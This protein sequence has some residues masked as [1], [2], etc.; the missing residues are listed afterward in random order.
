M[1]Q[2]KK[3]KARHILVEELED[4]QYILEKLLE[5]EDFEQLALEF[6][7]CD[8]SKRGGNLGT[9]YSGQ[10]TGPFE[11]ALHFLK[12]MEISAPI[13]SEFGHQIIQRLPI[14]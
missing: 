2:R 1:H 8:S 5:G 13:K 11:K 10:M 6:S 14:D 4:A 7:E 9:F 12:D 3:Y